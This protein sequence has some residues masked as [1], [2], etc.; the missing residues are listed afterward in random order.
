MLGVI[1]N[2]NALASQIQEFEFKIDLLK[3]DEKDEVM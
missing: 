1:E 2:S 3:E